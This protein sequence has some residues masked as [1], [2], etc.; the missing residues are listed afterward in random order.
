MFAINQVFPEEI[1]LLYQR[2]KPDFKLSIMTFSP[3]L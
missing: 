2:L 1:E 3:T